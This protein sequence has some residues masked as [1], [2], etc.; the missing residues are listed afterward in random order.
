M[1]DKAGPAPTQGPIAAD[2]VLQRISRRFTK[3]TGPPEFEIRARGLVALPHGRRPAAEGRGGEGPAAPAGAQGA[4]RQR[5]RQRRAGLHRRTPDGRYFVE[6]DGSGIDGTPEEIARLFSIA[7]PMISTKLLRLPQRGALGNGLRVVAGAV[8]ASEGSLVVTTRNRRIVLRPERDGSTAVVDVKPIDFPVGTRVEI[9]FGPALPSDKRALHWAQVANH[10]AHFGSVYTGNSSPHWYDAPQFLELLYAGGA[11]PVRELIASLDGCTGAKAGE[12]VAEAGLGRALCSAVTR[13]QAAKISQSNA[14]PVKP[15]RLGAV[16][17]EA[18]PER[19]YACSHG[20][21]QFGSIVPMAEIPFVVEAWAKKTQGDTVLGICVNRTPITGGIE[22]AR[23]KRDIDAY[24]CG[25]HHTIAQ[26]PREAQF[27]IWVNITTPFMPITSDGKAPNLEPFL[28]EIAR[29]VGKAVKKTHR[30]NARGSSQKD[31]VLDNLDE[32][33]AGVSGGKFRFNERQLFY[34]L[35]KIVGDEI[36]G[37]LKIGNFK[38]IITDHENE[39][40]E[41]PL[42]VSRAAR[43]YLSPAPRRDH[44]ARHADG[45]G[46][47][48]PG[49]DFQQARLHREGGIQRGAQ[50]CALGGAPRLHADVLEGFHDPRGEGLDR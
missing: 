42:N 31:I 22:A 26:A 16:G 33:V 28:G 35:R 48:A 3:L 19:A 1:D 6:D 20:Q 32:A 24:G 7:R 23:D 40:G 17:P 9:G 8:L 43:Q 50:G 14:R 44:H 39:N 21:A 25:L 49:M 47:R 10:F 2:R 41:I 34:V 5:A 13:K 45:R 30:P 36:G 18:S 15:Q 46:L 29:A 12:I 37:E 27:D 4:Y 11:R 38:A